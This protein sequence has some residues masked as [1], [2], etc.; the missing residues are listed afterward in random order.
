MTA[1]H[2]RQSANFSSGSHSYSKY[3]ILLPPPLAASFIISLIPV[4]AVT[5]FRYIHK[6]PSPEV[7]QCY[8]RWLVLNIVL[9]IGLV[10]S[11]CDRICFKC[12]KAKTVYFFK[13]SVSQWE[14]MY[15]KF[16]M[17]LTESSPTAATSRHTIF[18]RTRAYP[19]VRNCAVNLTRST[20]A[21]AG[22]LRAT[23]SSDCDTTH[24]KRVPSPLAVKSPL[25]QVVN[26][27]TARVAVLAD[28]SCAFFKRR[29]KSQSSKRGSA[30]QERAPHPLMPSPSDKGSVRCQ[31]ITQRVWWSS[32]TE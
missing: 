28:G 24:S 32:L 6:L 2:C 8:R 9:C 29:H 20:S 27:E 16:E 4:A 25:S 23:Q 18:G 7:F 1:T 26:D 22:I 3:V 13:C 19:S 30:V 5:A 14:W 12:F 11:D 21:P 17:G 15:R 31:L 10:L